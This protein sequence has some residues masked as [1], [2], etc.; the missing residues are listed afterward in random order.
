[1]RRRNG[2]LWVGGILAAA[3][4]ALI[5]VG[6]F[7]TPYDPTAISVGPKFAPPS[8]QHLLGTD[9]FGR[10]IL[11]RVMKGAGTTFTIGAATVAIGA[12]CGT[13]VGA[14][15]GYFGGVA[16]EVLMRLNDALTAFPSILLALVVISNLLFINNVVEPVAVVTEAAKRISAGSYGIRIENKYS[17]ELGELVDNINDMSLKIGRNEK[18][19]QEFISSVSHELRTPLTAITGW[20]ETLAYDE[21]IRGDSRRGIEIITREAGRL[22]KMVEELLEFTRIQDGRFTLHVSTVEL[23]ALVEDCLY[24]YNELFRHEDLAVT[25]VSPEEDLPEIPGDPERLSQ[26]F[27]NILDN[28]CKYGK[29]GKKIDV[30]ITHDDATVSVCIRD[31]GPGIPE[32]ELPFIVGVDATPPALEAVADGTLKGTVQNDAAGQAESILDLCCALASGQSAASAV[33]LE[34]GKYVWLEYTAVTQ[35]NLEDFLP[36]E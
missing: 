18:M 28:A 13:A 33:E 1:M 10:D 35:E 3:M 11:S 9:N 12:V 31:Y 32:A 15:T 30:N 34:D 17:D 21:A 2:Y 14:L 25:Y 22:T 29:N 8:L 20:A 6:F 16:D 24:T 5:L 19:K 23:P 26:V 7:W 36:E 27:L 4:A